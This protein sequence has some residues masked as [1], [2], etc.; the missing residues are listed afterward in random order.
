MIIFYIQKNPLVS[1]HNFSHFN[2]CYINAIFWE[3]LNWNGMENNPKTST[4]QKLIGSMPATFTNQT[5]NQK[6]QIS[7]TEFILDT[8]IFMLYFRKQCQEDLAFSS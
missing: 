6:K 4:V 1:K 2:G 3:F 8:T 5:V 7:I